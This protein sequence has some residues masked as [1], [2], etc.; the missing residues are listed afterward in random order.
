MRNIAIWSSGI[1]VF[2]QGPKE[3]HDRTAQDLETLGIAFGAWKLPETLAEPE[4]FGQ[5]W[6]SNENESAHL[7]AILLMP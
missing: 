3:E 2:F 6:C 4:W 7:V 1:T 5:V